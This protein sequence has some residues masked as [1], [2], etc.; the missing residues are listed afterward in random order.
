MV[1]D[2]AGVGVSGVMVTLRATGGASV[3]PMQTKTGPTGGAIV[4]W[5]AGP[6]EDSLTASV[7]GLADATIAARGVD[8]LDAL[9]YELRSVDPAY[10]VGLASALY[11]AGSQAAGAF[12]TSVE[13]NAPATCRDSG[14]GTYVR[15]DS[16][17][18]L[19]YANNFWDTQYS[20][21]QERGV[22]RGD[23]LLVSRADDM[24]APYA[25]TL[26]FVCKTSRSTA[27]K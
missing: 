14:W 23:T 4:S 21:H 12:Y 24:W 20:D 11:L 6:G 22:F 13:C 5:L 7:S 18:Y 3:T 10:V 16:V 19:N 1:T 27:C 17:L 26:A 25:F 2:S 9:T 8:T 15:S